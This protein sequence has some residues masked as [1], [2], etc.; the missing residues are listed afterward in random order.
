MSIIYFGVPALDRCSHF[1]YDYFHPQLSGSRKSFTWNESN[2]TK[3]YL[4]L[5]LAIQCA[6]LGGN[7]KLLKWLVDDHCCPLRSIRISNGK[8]KNSAGSYTPILTSKGR[9]LLGI[10]LGNRNIGIV[11]YLVVEKRMLLSAEKGLSVEVL[12][13]N[14]D[15]VLRVLPEEVLG[16]QTLDNIGRTSIGGGSTR[17]TNG[18]IE[19]HTDIDI[20]TIGVE[21]ELDGQ[22][23]ASADNECIICFDN[24]INCVFTPCGHQICCMECGNHISRCPV[25]A[26]DCTP[27][28]VFKP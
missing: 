19:S 24:R 18:M 27:M 22:A 25:C 10:A 6:V 28:R 11:R 12:A 20:A 15:L 3:R 14:L 4:T 23:D 13:Q 16:E 1:I 8:Q 9:S 21:A 7:L 26:V 5:V 2:F 17:S